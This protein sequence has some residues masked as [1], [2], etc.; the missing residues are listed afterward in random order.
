MYKTQRTPFEKNNFGT[1]I[2]TDQLTLYV[3][4]LCNTQCD[5]CAIDQQQWLL[6]NSWKS[7]LQE[8]S[9]EDFRT[10][11]HMKWIDGIQ[12]ILFQWKEPTL[13]WKLQEAIDITKSH[14]KEAIVFTNGIKKVDISPNIL[15]LHIDEFYN[16]DIEYWKELSRKNK[17]H[18]NLVI[19]ITATSDIERYINIVEKYADSYVLLPESPIRFNTRD[20][21]IIKKT[22]YL[23]KKLFLAWH[24]KYTFEHPIPYCLIDTNDISFI[25]DNNIIFGWTCQAPRSI[26]LNYDLKSSFP[27]IMLPNKEDFVWNEDITEHYQK[28]L[29][30]ADSLRRKMPKEE[31]YTCQ[32][33]IEKY[34]QGGC[35]I[36]RY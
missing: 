18:L 34:C 2:F 10:I 29:E 21:L 26:I 11:F 25:E 19:V 14:G 35:M 6:E 17:F 24:K 7:P 28:H 36:N 9:L 31:C 30:Y 27:C 16:T 1:K 12:S 5:Y 33:Y 4:N 3:N 23:L 13:W 15:N 20:K 8:M 32:Y 22:F